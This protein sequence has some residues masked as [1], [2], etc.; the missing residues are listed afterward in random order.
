[1]KLNGILGII[2]KERCISFFQAG[3]NR[4]FYNDYKI[5]FDRIHIN[6]Y[7]YNGYLLMQTVLKATLIERAKVRYKGRESLKNLKAH[8]VSMNR[9]KMCRIEGFH[10]QPLSKTLNINTI[11]MS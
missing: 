4:R 1:M 10:S 5:K 2:L 8:L 3:V 6:T 7:T 9:S 11:V